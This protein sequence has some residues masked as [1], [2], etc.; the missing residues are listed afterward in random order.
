MLHS[1]KSVSHRTSRSVSPQLRLELREQDTT[2][3]LRHDEGFRHD[4]AGGERSQRPDHNKIPPDAFSQNYFKTFFREEEELGR[5]GKGVVL[6]V[7]H[8][9]DKIDLGQFACK[10]VPVGDD[11]QFL[12]KVLVEAQLLQTLSHPNVVSYKHAWLENYQANTFSPVIPCAFILQEY[13]NS[14]D[15][16]RYI[17]GINKPMTT[18]ELKQ[19]ARIRRGSMLQTESTV[20]M[21]RILSFEEIFSFFKDI[22]SGL[23]YLHRN[24]YVHRDL[25]PHNCLLHKT[26]SQLRVLV[27]DFGEMQ[28]ADVFRESSGNTG[29]QPTFVIHHHV[30]PH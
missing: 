20:Q 25:K 21:P 5:G 19:H 17:F 23:H 9:I 16:H 14:G 7:R 26:G 11:S 10:R 30:R 8:I 27:S 28:S 24:G 18:E 12:R 4:D 2:H 22:A 13:C 15:L 6:L 3:V 1:S 29:N